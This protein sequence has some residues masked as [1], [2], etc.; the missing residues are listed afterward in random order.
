MKKTKL[1]SIAFLFICSMAAV[2]PA[3]AATTTP[4]TQNTQSFYTSID[5]YLTSLFGSSHA[6]TIISGFLASGTVTCCNFVSSAT[7]YLTGL[8]G[9]K[10]ATA[11]MNGTYSGTS[12]SSSGS[13]SLPINNNIWFLVVAAGMVGIKVITSKRKEQAID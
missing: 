13:T 2:S 9:A 8:F 7:S 3:H 6:S 10:Q 11:I 5:T 4:N 12:W 1:L